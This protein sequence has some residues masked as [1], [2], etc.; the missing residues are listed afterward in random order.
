MWWFYGVIMRF[1]YFLFCFFDL[2]FLVFGFQFYDV[3]MVVTKLGII[4]MFQIRGRVK[5]ERKEERDMYQLSLFFFIC[6][7]IVFL[8]S[9]INVFS[10]I[11]FVRMGFY[12]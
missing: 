7:V 12:D 10:Y 8:E 5:V 6:S 11:L 2:L 4:C 3:K 1:R 9:V